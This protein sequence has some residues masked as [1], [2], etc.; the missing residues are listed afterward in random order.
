MY[1]KS[2]AGRASSRVV[3]NSRSQASHIRGLFSTLR[4]TR[5]LVVEQVEES[6]DALHKLFADLRTRAFDHVHR[7]AS[8]G[9]G[10]EPHSRIL[11][12]E[13]VARA[14]HRH[15]VHAHASLLRP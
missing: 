15:P 8:G 4:S 2:I 3:S 1:F 11:Q 13:N 7:D 5:R 12:R 14:E 6:V 10:A 9:A